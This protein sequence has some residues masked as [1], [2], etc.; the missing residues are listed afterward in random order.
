MWD[1]INHHKKFITLRPGNCDFSAMAIL[2]Q[3]HREIN[4]VELILVSL[5]V[6]V[7]GVF[8]MTSLTIWQV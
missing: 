3:N 5:K 8:P 6:I 2:S 4:I 7:F 1:N